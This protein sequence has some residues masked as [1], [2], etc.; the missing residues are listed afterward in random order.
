[1]PL[2]KPLSWDTGVIAST[3][4]AALVVMGAIMWAA[5]GDEETAGANSPP[6]NHWTKH[7]SPTRREVAALVQELARPFRLVSS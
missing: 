5:M 1:V 7:H 6:I 4:L 3:I 2:V